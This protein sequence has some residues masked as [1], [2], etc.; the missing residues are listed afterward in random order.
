MFW[1]LCQAIRPWETFG[2]HLRETACTLYLVSSIRSPEN[3]TY[4]S[5]C[6]SVEF[7][8]LL[9]Y[10]LLDIISNSLAKRHAETRQLRE[11]C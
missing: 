8:C 1:E 9:A 3:E 5:G 7:I 2:L 6:D 4:P 11:F 10:H